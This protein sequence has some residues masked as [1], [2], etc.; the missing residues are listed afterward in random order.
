V[1]VEHVHVVI[2]V[3]PSEAPERV[4]RMLKAAGTR[5]IRM[6]PVPLPPE[7]TW[8]R[9]GSTRYLWSLAALGTAVR[10]VTLHEEERCAWR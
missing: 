8:S 6:M 2:S 4:M 7:R 1:R 5:R 10:Y 9:H 3:G